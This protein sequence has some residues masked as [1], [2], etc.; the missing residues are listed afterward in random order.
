[1][2]SA[3]IPSATTDPFT[4]AISSGAAAPLNAHLVTCL[5]S[6]RDIH[7]SKY[8]AFVNIHTSDRLLGSLHVHESGRTLKPSAA[9]SIAHVINHTFLARYDLQTAE[10]F[11]IELRTNHPAIVQPLTDALAN[12]VQAIKLQQAHDINNAGL[13][14]QLYV[15]GI[16]HALERLRALPGAHTAGHLAPPAPWSGHALGLLG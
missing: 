7:R 6:T 13:S 4:G 9:D 12:D 3:R 1:M 11:T 8:G 5:A 16:P 10:D 15:L 2:A 14:R